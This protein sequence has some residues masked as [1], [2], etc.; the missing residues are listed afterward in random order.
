[1]TLDDW[2]STTVIQ[3]LLQQPGIDEIWRAKLATSFPAIESSDLIWMDSALK[4]LQHKL[5]V[6]PSEGGEGAEDLAEVAYATCFLN[7]AFLGN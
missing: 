2:N 3:G 7:S 5:E 1:M 4:D 6:G